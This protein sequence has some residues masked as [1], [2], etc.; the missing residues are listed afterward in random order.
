MPSTSLVPSAERHPFEVL[1]EEFV[2]RQRRGEH[3]SLSEYAEKH[4]ELA[5]Q[6]RDLFPALVMVERLKPQGDAP[7]DCV[8]G[9][10]TWPKAQDVKPTARLGDY[11]LVREVAR[12]GMGVVYEAVQESL[13]RHVALKVLPGN[14]R[15]SPSQIERFQLEARSA[16]RLHHPNIVP[17]HGV[18][19]HEGVYYYAMQFI[20]GHGLDAVLDD[21]RRLRGLTRRAETDCLD[22]PIAINGAERTESAVLACSLLTGGF[23]NTGASPE[24]PVAFTPTIALPRPD[25][26]SLCHSTASPIFPFAQSIAASAESEPI[27]P[28]TIAAPS[29]SSAL[30]LATEA[31]FFRSVGRIGTQVADAL[32]Y[33]HQEGVLHRDI[34]PSNLL[35]DVTGKIWVTDFGLAKLEGSSGPTR[36]GDI[37]GTVRY[38]APERFDGWSD[39]RSDVYSVGA[40]LYELLTL[41]PVFSS[42][43][44]A[45]LIEKVL[46]A[47]P[48][49]PRRLEPKIPRDLETIVL[50]AIAKEPAD[51]Y[52]SADAL[53][54][55]LQRFLDDR[56]IRA[57]RSTP[58]EQFWR[59]CRRNP[60]PAAALATAAGA[61]VMLAIGSAAMA[62]KFRDQRDQV[63]RAQTE[64]RENLLN[65]LTAQATAT[66]VS[67]RPGQ[68]FD[69]LR[70][71]AQAASLARALKLPAKELDRLRD[72]AVACLA[73]PDL[74]SSGRAIHRPPSVWYFA[75]DYTMTRYALRFRDGRV[76]VRRVA[77]EQE[78]ARFHAAGDRGVPVF[79]FSPDGRYLAATHDPEFALTVWD[80]DR[81]SP[82]VVDSGP[83]LSSAARFSPDSRQIALIHKDGQLLIYD[84]ATRQISR[85]WHLPAPGDLAFRSDGAQLAVCLNVLKA[86][87]CQILDVQSGRVVDTIPL[88]MSGSLSWSPN[89]ST[90]AIG[91]D[92][93]KIYLWDVATRTRR[94][95]LVGH[96]HVGLRTDF[97]PDSSLVA[98]NG[99]E[100]RLWL[101]DPVLGRPWLNL[102][103]GY[104]PEFSQDGRIVVALEDTLVPYQ[105]NPARE[106]RSFSHAS[107]Q[108][109]RYSDACIRQDGRLMAVGTSQGVVLWDL[110]R[111]A[112]LACLP[113]GSASHIKILASG[114]LITSAPLGVWRWPIRL[115]LDQGDFRIGP[116]QQ[117]RLP[118]GDCGVSFDRSERIAASADYTVAHVVDHERYFDLGPVDECRAVAISPDGEWLATGSHGRS[119]AQVWR[120]HDG[121]LVADLA[122]EGLVAVDFS[123]DGKWL[124]TSPAPCRLW[125]VGTWREGKR[126][127]GSGLAFSPDGR[128]VVVQDA[129]SV[130]RLVESATGRTLVRL[131]SPDLHVAAQAAFSAD[132]SRVV[133]TTNDGPAVH[134]WDLRAI[135]ERL[136]EL[137]L[138]WD[139]PAYPS[140][141]SAS[142][143]MRA[144]SQ[145]RIDYGPLAGHLELF[146]ESPQVLLDR[147]GARLKTD[148]RDAETYHL[149]GHV[150]FNLNRLKEAV[151]DISQA[152]ALQPDDAHLLAVRGEA[153]NKLKESDAAIE[154]LAR[155][156]ERRPDQLVVRE[157]LA[158]CYNNRAWAL[159]T[160]PK[161][162]RDLTRALRLAQRAVELN[163]DQS[164]FLNTLG[165]VLC[166]AGEFREAIATLETSLRASNG[167]FD[168]FDLFF[169]AEAHHRLGDRGLAR[170]CFERGASWLRDQTRLSK[171]YAKELTEFRA[172]AEAVLAEPPGELPQN[173]F[174]VTQ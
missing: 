22:G 134:V 146:A 108:A 62:W 165:V 101:W 91:C 123:P 116:P 148:P 54:D 171:Q 140:D 17:V 16:G 67:R 56:P 118:S 86:P 173:V 133:V 147:Y 74:E 142:E 20:R 4:P 84:V 129:N 37:L 128:A 33:A 159:A 109:L 66:R 145:P 14:A 139:A 97:H 89:D 71:I 49:A 65:A 124:L 104:W 113:I 149:R 92:D 41:R 150:L 96:S 13:G 61:V 35:L 68:R 2:E 46:H 11:R 87:V 27:E 51:R 72:E 12:G 75:F 5:D 137:G 81:R 120:L 9:Q 154:D 131:E 172:E 161:S 126:P 30:S 10:P 102:R 24:E 36:T 47:A 50:K 21:L 162:D 163:S 169:L 103:T 80:I 82:V 48:E 38:M 167:R 1:A 73:L 119:G 111:G 7:S 160:G 152:I 112:E 157:Q 99:W 164:M 85:Q 95:T 42:A 106:Y 59:W 45:E 63:R 29:D 90:L 19:E 79:R 40:T 57:R 110:A 125:E 28:G 168:G 100:G 115:D 34:K 143:S 88:P 135:R 39:R 158:W 114:D 107:A 121:A 32:S 69:S 174:A 25:E 155:S 105:I 141:D 3:P 6:I 122:I 151:A 15:L 23:A 138:D 76:L 78:V 44:Q 52:A 8:K 53:R 77:D 144:L 93:C 55:D 117:L 98:S 153:R 127:G 83:V 60:L 31:E 18:G 58:M 94:G 64:T 170:D 132:G 156:L 26:L 43:H 136:A 166:R 130:L 70:A